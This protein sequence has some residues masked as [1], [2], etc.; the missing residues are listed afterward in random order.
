MQVLVISAAFQFFL[1]K[2]MF[3][4][5]SILLANVKYKHNIYRTSGEDI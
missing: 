5:I 2:S 4:N 3:Q 1:L